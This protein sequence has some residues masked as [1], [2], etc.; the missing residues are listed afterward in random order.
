ME[1]N[2]LTKEDIPFLVE[3]RNECRSLLHNNDIFTI[4]EGIKWFDEKVD[5]YYL[6]TNE[7]NKI[8]YFRTSNLIIGDSIYIGA[9]IHQKYRGQGLAKRA[10]KQFI[11]FIVNEYKLNTLYLE[12]LSTNTVAINLYIK[13]GFRIYDIEKEVIERDS[14]MVDNIKME[15]IV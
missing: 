7:G 4:E 2:K 3:V 6:I 12:V 10:Y 5:D 15:Y 9:D 13:V 14:K 8:G 1:I 11:S